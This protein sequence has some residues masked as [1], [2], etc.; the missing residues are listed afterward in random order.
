MPSSAGSAFDG[1]NLFWDG[2]L[3]HRL[4]PILASK[5]GTEL[6]HNRERNRKQKSKRR[7]KKL[8]FDF[9]EHELKKRLYVNGFR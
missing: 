3:Q 1:E 5:I 8:W 9:D 7:V 4:E 6:L 2:N